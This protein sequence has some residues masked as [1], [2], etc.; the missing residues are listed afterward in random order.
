MATELMMVKTSDF[1]DT[2]QESF[3]LC[4]VMNSVAGLLSCG[5][6]RPDIRRGWILSTLRRKPPKESIKVSDLHP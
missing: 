4:P 2:Y 5:C 6:C 3:T 1:L